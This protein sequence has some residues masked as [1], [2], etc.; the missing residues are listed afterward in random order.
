MG[1]GMKRDTALAIAS[2]TRHQ[3]YH[4]PK[5]HKRPGRPKSTHTQRI[6]SRGIELAENG[7]VIDQ[8]MKI[9]QDPDLRC[10][11]KRMH[12]QLQLK[13]FVINRKKVYSM[14]QG[15]GILKENKRKAKSGGR[16]FVRYRI[17]NPTSPLTVLE[18]DIKQHWIIKD[19]RSAYTIT[20][21]DA[22]TRETLGRMTGYTMKAVQ[23]KKLWD[24]IIEQHLEPAAMALSSLQ[25][26]IRCDNGPQF[27]AQLIRD[28][29]R[30]NKLLQVY[31][32]PYTP[33]ENGHIESFHSIMTSCVGKEFFSIHEL[34]QRLERFYEMY[35]N[36]RSHTAT[37]GLP[38]VLF[39]KAW[40]QDMVIT[41]FDERKPTIIKLKYPLYEI[42]GKLNRKEHLANPKSKINSIRKKG[43]E[44][45]PSA[46]NLVTSVLTSPSVASCEAKELNKITHILATHEIVR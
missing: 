40:E 36:Y 15:I 2:L 27:I 43:G 19:R 29:F 32:N 20:V 13:G 4:V 23:V 35:N 30:D 28:Y 10:G 6:T 41:C 11:S 21:I 38:P 39:R 17:V 16:K 37:K 5:D 14:M 24:Q 46:C 12:Q 31:T 1:K 45:A 44:I 34:D 9:E 22:F 8:I 3:F 7:E 42:S 25:I 18:M 33:Q 26:E